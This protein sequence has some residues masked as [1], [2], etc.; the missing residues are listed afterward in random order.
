MAPCSSSC[1]VNFGEAQFVIIVFFFF[2]FTCCLLR[3][4]VGA[5]KKNKTARKT[6]KALPRWVCVELDDMLA[7]AQCA[8]SLCINTC[9][10]EGQGLDEK[11]GK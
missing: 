9:A 8:A 11:K 5:E 3:P 1:C 10:G 7:A 4:R 2:C 6:N